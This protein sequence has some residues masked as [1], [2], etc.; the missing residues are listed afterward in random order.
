MA[1]SVDSRPLPSSTV[2]IRTRCVYGT[3]RETSGEPLATRHSSCL[4][5]TR[6]K[7]RLGQRLRFSA[8][9]LEICDQTVRRGGAP[10]QSSKPG[11]APTTTKPGDAPTTIWG[12]GPFGLQTGEVA[13]AL[14]K[15]LG[16]DGRPPLAD[17]RIVRLTEAAIMFLEAV[18]QFQP[19]DLEIRQPKRLTARQREV[20]ELLVAGKGTSEIALELRI[21][22][23]T[24]YSH[25]QAAYNA[26]GAHSRDEA[27]S[28][29]LRR[30][31]VVPQVQ[32]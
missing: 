14:A 7:L 31:L 2:L 23:D 13:A 12:R 10:L 19:S 16:L 3:S 17:E 11:D 6:S 22:K 15:T 27:I 18:Q 20:L 4:L 25:T 30:Q 8:G 32:D 24:V 5:C 21:S 26:L 29:A 9:C 28:E 1:A